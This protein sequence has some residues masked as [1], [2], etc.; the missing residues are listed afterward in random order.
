MLGVAVASQVTKILKRSAA[1]E[2]CPYVFPAPYGH[3]VLPTRASRPPRTSTAAVHTVD[4][5]FGGRATR[6]DRDDIRRKPHA[7]DPEAPAK[8]QMASDHIFI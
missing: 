8:T 2:H 7:H 1:P 4:I 3:A 6:D 5:E